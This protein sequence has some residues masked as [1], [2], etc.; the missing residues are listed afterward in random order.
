MSNMG[1]CDGCSKATGCYFCPECK[2]RA[3]TT[4]GDLT[5]EAKLNREVSDIEIRQLRH[6]LESKDMAMETLTKQRDRAQSERDAL[7]RE[8]GR[9]EQLLSS[10]DE[11]GKQ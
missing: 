1:F 6:N 7:C 4:L 3:I 11:L 8:L 5:R 2:K 9:L 10:L